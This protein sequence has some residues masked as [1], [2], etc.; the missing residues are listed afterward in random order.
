M[1]TASY[2]IVEVLGSTALDFVVIDAEHAPFDRQQ[3]DVSI[4]AARAAG[5]DSLVRLPNAASDTVLNVLDVGA[6]GILVPHALG[7][8]SARAVAA[9]ARYRDGERGFS[10]SSRAGGYG[11]VGMTQLVDAADKG[12]SVVC[13]IEDREAVE[14]IDEIAAVSEVDCLFIGRADLAV[15]YGTFDPAHADVARAVEKV[16]R[17]CRAAGKTVGIFLADERGLSQYRDMGVTM[18]VIGSDQSMLRS[19]ANGVI[20]AFQRLA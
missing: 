11:T 14:R 16:C 15:S 17:S 20:E 2:Q 13:Q 6:S 1:K 8:D 3:L 7:A 19:Q 9:R 10:N 18:F 4:L 12:V 5:I